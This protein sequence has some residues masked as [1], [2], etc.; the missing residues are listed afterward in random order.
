MNQ[1][2]FTQRHRDTWSRTE[3]IL[4]R[5]EKGGDWDVSLAELPALYRRCCQHLA[6]ARQRQY[7][8]RLEDRLHTI[9]LRGYRVLYGEKPSSWRAPLRFL[10]ADFPALVRAHAG[11]FWLATA[12]FYLPALAMGGLVMQEPDAIYSLI[13]PL[14]AANYEEMYRVRDTEERGAAADLQMFGIY[15]WNNISIAFRTFAAGLFA[16]LGSL[17][18]LV[19]NGLFLGGVMAHLVHADSAVNLTSFVIT[20]GAFE[21]T[22]LVISGVAGLKLGAAIIA[23][24]RRTRAEALRHAG[25]ECAQLIFGVTAMLLIAAFVEAFW[26]STAAV[27]PA[28][29]YLSGAVAWIAVL[30]YLAMAGR[31]SSALR[32]A[33][34][35]LDGP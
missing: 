3:A 27:P 17:F 24:G 25:P 5:A 12:L 28:G 26:S 6:L 20:H 9:A 13:S 14:D 29:K 15:I 11:Y 4:D 31:G 16:G 33:A 30:V 19:F 8:A 10:A 32:A 23:P 1:D 22:G 2:L 7:G 35:S 34:G 21:L 18:F